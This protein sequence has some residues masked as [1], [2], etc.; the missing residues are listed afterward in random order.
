MSKITIAVGLILVAVGVIFFAT[1]DVP[2]G[3][4][5]V[6]ALIPAFVGLPVAL[7]G[8]LGCCKPGARKHAAHVAVILTLLGTLGGIG[9]GF[10]NM[11]TEGKETAVMAQ[12]I[13]GVVCLVHVILSVKSFIAAKKAREA[14]AGA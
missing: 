12:F 4:S 6:T 11:G 14:A 3:K 13:M 9:M 7:L 1:A 5:R 10:K 2:E 8:C